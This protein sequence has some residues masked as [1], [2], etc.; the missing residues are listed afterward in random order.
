MTTIVIH[1]FM[2]STDAGGV[3]GY[4][5]GIIGTPAEE[6][7]RAQFAQDTDTSHPDYLPT[8]IHR[9]IERTIPDGLDPADVT[10]HLD[11]D[12]DAMEGGDFDNTPALIAKHDPNE[13]ET[14][15]LG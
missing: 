13:G 10:D 14:H 6:Q 4:D 5:W 2:P 11:A 1:S 9:L 7:V 15:G 8:H 3:G 12:L